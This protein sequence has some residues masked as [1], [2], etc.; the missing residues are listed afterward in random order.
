MGGREGSKIVTHCAWVCDP[1][2]QKDCCGLF[3]L[4]EFEATYEPAQLYSPLRLNHTLLGGFLRQKL[5]QIGV[6]RRGLNLHSSYVLGYLNLSLNLIC[7]NL[8]RYN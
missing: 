5:F 1:H 6:D 3:L 8:A 4:L 7:S 2:F